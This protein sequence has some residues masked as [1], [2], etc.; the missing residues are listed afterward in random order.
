MFDSKGKFA[1]KEKLEKFLRSHT[2]TSVLLWAVGGGYLLY[3][4]YK[5]FSEDMSAANPVLI[6]ATAIF[7]ALAGI[8]LL[9]VGLYAIKNK[10]YMAQSFTEDAREKTDDEA[11]E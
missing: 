4:A 11:D 9:A 2:K 1:M 10:C 6:K 3:L 8:V 7:F 5:M